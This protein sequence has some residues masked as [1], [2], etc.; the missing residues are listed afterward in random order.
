MMAMNMMKKKRLPRLN[1]IGGKKTVMVPNPWG[2]GVEE[3]YDFDVTKSDKLYDFLL[4]RGQIKLPTNHIMLTPD[5][6]RNE[7]FYKFHNATSHSTSEKDYDCGEIK[8]YK[9]DCL[10]KLL[11]SNQ[12]QNQQ[13][14]TPQNF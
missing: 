3:S 1:E 11:E 10:K 9:N 6:L 13:H 8:H 4:E 2:K 5:Q 14:V 7:K 12:S